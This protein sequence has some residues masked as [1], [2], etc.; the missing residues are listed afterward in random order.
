MDRDAALEQLAARRFDLLVVGGGII[1]AGIAE[2]ASAHGLA[3]A[4]VDRGDFASA[5]STASS[6]LIHGG[7]RYLRLGDVG[8]VREAHHERRALTNVVAP[9][10]VHRLPFLFPFYED[11]PYRPWFVQ[12]GIIAYSMIAH[13]RLHWLVGADEA[14]ALVPPLRRRG[15]RSCGLYA[16]AWTNDGR[17]TIANIRGAAD[18]GAVVLNYAEVVSIGAGG[19]EVVADGRTIPVRAGAIVNATGPWVDRVR[20][21]EDPAARPSIRLSKGV[22]VLVDGAH[23]WQAALTIAHDQVRVSFAVP[24][25]GMLL[26]GTTDTEHD[27]EP[28]DVAVTDDDVREVLGEAQVAVEGLGPARASYCGLRALPVGEGQTANARRETVFTHGPQGMLSVAGGKLTTYRRIALDA[29]EAVGVKNLNRR[30]RPLPGATGLADVAWPAA[31]DNAT[32]SH[33]LHLYGSLA[34]EVLKGAAGDPSLLE[35]LVPG[36]PDVRAQEAYARSHEWART[37]EDVLRR[38]TTGWLAPG[39]TPS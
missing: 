15:L 2:A 14:A 18:R 36:R 37:P 1:G 34:A 32:R 28:E 12:S 33:L 27:G 17:L 29:L 35:P 11:G 39:S 16:D 3:V 10:L 19:A 9:H 21:L 26:L 24:W 31:L 23:D 22:H 6:K 20:R 38:R 13:S 8:L 7:L 25:E 30:P 4:L 5:T